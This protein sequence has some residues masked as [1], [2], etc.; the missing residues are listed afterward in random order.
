MRANPYSEPEPRRIPRQQ[1]GER[2]VAQL[3]DA[4][5]AVIGSAGYEAATMSSI[6]ERAG[7]PIGS[8][9]QFFPNKLA[10]THALRTQYG[11]DYEKLLIDLKTDAGALSIDEL[12]A[13]LVRMTI[14]FVENHPAFLALLD[15]PMSTRSPEALRRMLRARLAGCLGAVHPGLAKNKAL[16]L[17]AVTLQMVKGLNQLYAEA[18]VRQRNVF[19]A[20]YRAAIASY[21]TA[22]MGSCVQ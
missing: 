16:R 22:R 19:V 5:A 15:A 12:A 8:L 6:A 1:R 7:A 9:Y 3:L 4:A 21:L 20:E 11:G 17:A 10:I 13:R 2:R 18:G 14:G